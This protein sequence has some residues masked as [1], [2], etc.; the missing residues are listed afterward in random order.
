[1][2]EKR[3]SRKRRAIQDHTIS[4]IHSTI[5]SIQDSVTT[6]QEAST[7]DSSL[8][9]FTFAVATTG[10]RTWDEEEQDWVSTGCQVGEIGIAYK[11]K[12]N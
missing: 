5:Q 12:L 1:M 6:S 11:L 10:C 9:N 4:S 3:S 2:N 7:F 8:S